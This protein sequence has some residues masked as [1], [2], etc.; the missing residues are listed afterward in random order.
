MS[1]TSVRYEPYVEENYPARLL[2]T[3]SAYYTCQVLLV[4]VY[5]PMMIIITM[6][7][8]SEHVNC[9]CI[10]KINIEGRLEQTAVTRYPA[11]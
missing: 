8:Q 7:N 1:E 5:G 10:T 11:K 4:R 3:L 9:V 2:A 6:Y